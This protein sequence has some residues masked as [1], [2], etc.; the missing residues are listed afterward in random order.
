MLLQGTKDR[1][2]PEPAREEPAHHVVVA[3]SP[4]AAEPPLPAPSGRVYPPI[5]ISPPPLGQAIA[6]GLSGMSRAT[7]TVGV[8]GAAL[9]GVAMV[10]AIVIGAIVMALGF[11]P[12]GAY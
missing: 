3:P 6:E 8:V 11:D 2:P 4:A 12:S 7:L 9:I 5:V 10:V 1:R